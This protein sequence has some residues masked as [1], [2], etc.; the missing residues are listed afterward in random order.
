MFSLTGFV[1]LPPFT[2]FVLVAFTRLLCGNIFLSIV[3][4]TQ[5]V[6]SF[7]VTWCVYRVV[8]SLFPFF[9]L[10]LSLLFSFLHSFPFSTIHILQFSL[11]LFPRFIHASSL[12][13]LIFLPTDPQR[14]VVLNVDQFEWMK[15]EETKDHSGGCLSTYICT[16]Y[17]HFW[18]QKSDGWKCENMTIGL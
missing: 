1:F 16:V 14:F 8:S 18:R 9:T 3:T 5:C 17:S 13:G 4:C 6:S 7:T 15:P 10:F 11:S 12:F 2:Q